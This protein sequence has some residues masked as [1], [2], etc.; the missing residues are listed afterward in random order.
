MLSHSDGAA[1]VCKVF[2]RHVRHVSP[3][4]MCVCVYVWLT[5]LL[6]LGCCTTFLRLEP[7]PHW[8]QL[9]VSLNQF[10]K[11]AERAQ[12]EA[13]DDPVVSSSTHAHTHMYTCTMP[14]TV[15]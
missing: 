6:L 11:Q 14:Y 10:G 2:Q 3:P 13:R 12:D 1:R 8:L 9:L 5:E 15:R 4:Y 7:G